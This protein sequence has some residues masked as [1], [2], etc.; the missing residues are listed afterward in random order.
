MGGFFDGI[1]DKL[2][3]GLTSGDF[4]SSAFS[5]AATSLA[6][7]LQAN[8]EDKQLKAEQERADKSDLLKLQLEALKAKFGGGGG[9]GARNYMTWGD[10]L[11]ANNAAGSN[12]LAAI[13]SLISAMQGPLRRG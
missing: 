10:A 6:G 5:T 12:K 2:S 7:I 13:N 3:E 8:R 1:G 9:G 11:N 4:L